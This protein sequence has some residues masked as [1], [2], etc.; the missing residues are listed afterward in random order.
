MLTI[1]VAGYGSAR[2]D[3]HG[4]T[5]ALLAGL[6]RAVDP[7]GDGAVDDAVR[8]A[9][10]GV[11][12]PYAGFADS[13][14]AQAV[15]G[16]G[17]LGTLVVAPAGNE[18]RARPPHGVVGSPGGARAA[19]AAGATRGR[20]RPAARHGDAWASASSRGAAALGGAPPG[21]GELAGPVTSTD[22]A[23]LLRG[24]V[25]LAGRVALVRAGAN[26]AAQAAAAAEAGAKAVLLADPGD[27]PLPMLSAG[28]AA[29][30]RDRADR[31]RREGRPRGEVRARRCPSAAW[32][33]RTSDRPRAE[34][35]P[36][37]LARPGLR[38]LAEAGRARARRGASPPSAWWPAPPSPP[39]GSR[40]ARRGSPGSGPP[41]RPPGSAPPC[42]P[43]STAEAGARR[44]PAVPLGPLRLTRSGGDVVGVRF[45][46]GAFDR[47]DPLTTGTRIEP[48]ARLDL[49]LVDASGAVRQRLTPVDGARDLLP[50]EYAYRLPA[51]ALRD[52]APGR[53]R[54]RATA[55]APRREPPRTRRSRRLRGRMTVTLYTRPGCHLCDDARAALLERV[56]QQH[57]FTLT[58]IDIESDDALHRAYL[59]RI[60]VILLDGEHVADYFVDEAALAARL[61]HQPLE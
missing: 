45:A 44:A 43:R 32:S 23:A 17:K 4:T 29:G 28:R 36:V 53:Y 3:V 54:F 57:P 18:G 61:R 50:A 35:A 42:K 9:L 2:P 59:E 30:A 26:P 13:A 7:N 58:E 52:L 47:G 37:L 41:R 22:S 12:A 21:G 11:S 49:E 14:E 39:R 48:A 19:L 34:P 20:R 1:R 38:R 5:D 24:R 40:C 51:S 15:R 6:E 25:R 46:L 55:R 10:V 27:R 56:Q 8:V 33:S 60:P 16:A 31:R